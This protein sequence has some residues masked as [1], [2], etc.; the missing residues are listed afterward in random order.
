MK[1]YAFNIKNVTDKPLRAVL[2]GYN[3]NLLKINHGSDL[4]VVVW[5]MD[6]DVKYEELLIQSGNESFKT[7]E[8][9]FI[10][11]KPQDLPKPITYGFQDL[12]A[13]IKTPQSKF[14]DFFKPDVSSE[15]YPLLRK[16]AFDVKVQEV[17][18]ST[19]F[20]IVPIEPNSTIHLYI[21][22][23]EKTNPNF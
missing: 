1:P 16:F 3:D 4:G 5:P 11:D 23:Y 12:N 15:M 21:S 20:F 17:I 8:L 6:P 18:N 13:E 9:R 2:L 19:N 7:H 22:K 14:I 10:G